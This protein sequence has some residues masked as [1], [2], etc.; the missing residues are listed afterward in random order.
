MKNWWNIWSKESGVI[1]ALISG[2][3]IATVAVGVIWLVVTLVF[4]A[5]VDR[6]W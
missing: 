4:G 5:N 6:H 2:M 1:G 3:I